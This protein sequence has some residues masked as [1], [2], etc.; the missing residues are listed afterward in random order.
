[1]IEHIYNEDA[2]IRRD[3]NAAKLG[4]YSR[5]SCWQTI[6]KAIRWIAAPSEPCDYARHSSGA[7]RLSVAHVEH[8]TIRVVRVML[9]QAPGAESLTASI[10]RSEESAL[11]A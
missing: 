4:G 7:A 2:A 11:A 5:V 10:P 1:M 6:A 9:A 8:L 3:G